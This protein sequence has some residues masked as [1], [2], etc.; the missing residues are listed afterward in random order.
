MSTLFGG[1]LCRSVRYEIRSVPIHTFYCH[2]T[3]CQKETGGPFAT[4][5]FLKAESVSVSGKMVSYEVVGDSGKIVT[6]KFCGICG[7]PIVTIFESDPD[8]ICIK[9]CS[10]DDAGWLKPEFHLYMKSKQPWYEIADDLPRY[11]GDMEW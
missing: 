1:C 7:C 2:C 8:H 10:L 6:R 5:L 11:Q 9:A 4:E 3:D